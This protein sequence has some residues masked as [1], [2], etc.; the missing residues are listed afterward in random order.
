MCLGDVTCP[1]DR[2]VQGGGFRC[3]SVSTGVG[4]NPTADIHFVQS[5]KKIILC[6]CSPGWHLLFQQSTT[7]FFSP[8]SSEGTKQ[9]LPTPCTSCMSE[10]Y[11]KRKIVQIMESIGV[12]LCHITIRNSMTCFS[13]SIAGKAALLQSAARKGEQRRSQEGTEG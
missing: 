3:H 5:R 11:S 12:V 7:T 6:V 10:L 2:A 8:S 4:S 13:S 9:V 1:C